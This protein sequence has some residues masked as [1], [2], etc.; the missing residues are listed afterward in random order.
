MCHPRRS[1]RRAGWWHSAPTRA[2]WAGGAWAP[3]A[4]PALS[5]SRLS[6]VSIRRRGRARGGLVGM[7]GSLKNRRDEPICVL[8][9][10]RGARHKN[11]TPRRAP[12]VF[13]PAASPATASTNFDMRIRHKRT[14]QRTRNGKPQASARREAP[15]SRT[16]TLVRAEACRLP[17]RVRCPGRWQAI[18]AQSSL[19]R[20]LSRG[21]SFG[22]RSGPPGPRSRIS[23]S[24]SFCFFVRILSSFASTSFWSVASSF[25]CASVISS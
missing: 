6:R 10:G 25:F 8:R 12:S 9:G 22:P 18:P 17:F 23:L 24:C 19:R 4:A 11:P 13:T 2:G 16:L 7:G 20:P 5:S 1:A 3:G 21:P 15:S 14:R